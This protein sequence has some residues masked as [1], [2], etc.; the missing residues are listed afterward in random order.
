MAKQ[1]S[2]KDDGRGEAPPAPSRARTRGRMPELHK[3]TIGRERELG[4][5]EREKKDYKAVEF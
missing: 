3:T 4:R 5:E 2:D 1:R